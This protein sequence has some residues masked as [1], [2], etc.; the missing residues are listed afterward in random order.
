N[1]V[2]AT[3][4]YTVTQRIEPSNKGQFTLSAKANLS[5]VKTYG[6]KATVSH[7]LDNN[8]S[9][10]SYSAA[11]DHYPSPTIDLGG[12]Q[13]VTLP[14][15]IESGISDVDYLWST[16]ATTP[17]IT[18]DNPG[19]YWLTVTN[20]YGCEASDTITLTISSVQVI[21]GTNTVVTVFPN[22][23]D[24]WITVRVEPR[25]PAKFVIELI[26]PSGQRVYSHSIEQ[27]QQFDHRIDVN[28][29]ASGVYI[30]RVSSGGKWITVR[31][32][33]QR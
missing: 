3:E 18:V 29:F 11:V 14:Y 22:P 20:S 23:S 1:Q 6:L 12:D 15:T 7:A 19:E 33:I 16:G 32:V 5:Q 25:S 21:P 30:L 10:N 31:L 26:S 24:Q 27:N 13:E 28:S 8:T 9:N 4:E 2:V 17:S